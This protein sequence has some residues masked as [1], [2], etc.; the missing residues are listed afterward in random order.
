MSN[1]E[2]IIE[3]L[4]EYFPTEQHCINYF[5]ENRWNGKPPT[6]PYDP[7]SKVY[8]LADGWYK[9]KNT[10]KRFSIRTGTVFEDSNLPLQKWFV[11]FY[12]LSS[13]KKGV[14]TR[15]LVKYIKVTQKT[16]W[17]MSQRLRETFEHPNFKNMLDGFVEIDETFIGGKNKNR[18]WDKKVPNSQGRSWKDKTPVWGA[19]K[20]GGYVTAQA[21]PDTKQKTL[22]LMIE[23]HVEKGSYLYSDEWYRHSSNLGEDFKH[24]I[25]N[26]KAK[27]YVNGRASTNLIENF[28]SH[29]KRGIYGIYHWISRKHTQRYVNEFTF[30]FNTRNYSDRYRFDLMLGSAV[31]KRLTYQQLI[32]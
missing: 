28:W 21:V 4:L 8:E 25:V 16:A 10:G 20:R 9:C 3:F 13:N 22:E 6:S 7:N 32:N 26:H 19:I 17:F 29:L 15:Q 24:E 1:F 2:S 5:K 18:H 14:S 23:K 11:A 31:G 12:L 27:Q 30:R